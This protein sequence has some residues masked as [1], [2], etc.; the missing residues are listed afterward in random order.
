MTPVEA[1]RPDDSRWRRSRAAIA[2][3]GGVE[4]IVYSSIARALLRRPAVQAGAV[5]F[6]YH[7]GAVA[8]F[9][10]FIVLSAFELVVLDLILQRWLVAR[11]VIDVLDAWGL[12][13]MIGLLCA[14]LMRPHTVGPRRHPRARRT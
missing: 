8:I 12:V 13:W 1:A 2:R 7:G 5:G 11:I 9:V 3:A 14:H 10:I 6:R 4:R